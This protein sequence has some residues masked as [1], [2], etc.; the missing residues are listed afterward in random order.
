VMCHL[1]NPLSLTS[2]WTYSKSWTHRCI[3]KIILPIWK[4]RR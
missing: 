1:L 3:S 2:F 4:A